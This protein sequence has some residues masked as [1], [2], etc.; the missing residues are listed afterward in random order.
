[1]P[2]NKNMKDA[3]FFWG[4]AEKWIVALALIFSV[5]VVLFYLWRFW[6]LGLGD[7]AI[8]AGFGDFVGGLVS[9]IL[10]FFTILLLIRS[11]KVQQKELA[12]ANSELSG[13]RLVHSQNLEMRHR[14]A[15]LPEFWQGLE[16]KHRDFHMA[17]T[18]DRPL[19]SNIS[20]LFSGPVQDKI[21]FSILEK[22]F[23][24]AIGKVGVD[25]RALRE[26]LRSALL[27]PR[28]EMH[29]DAIWREYSQLGQRAIA[30]IAYSSDSFTTDKVTEMFYR[31]YRTVSGFPVLTE[32][33]CWHV[34]S[35]VERALEKRKSDSIIPFYQASSFDRPE[36]SSCSLSD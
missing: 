34:R 26:Q 14:E 31:A 20:L 7:Q 12:I 1:M 19:T 21:S 27:D 29:L 30:V 23:Y 10:G 4:K 18:T 33:E 2:D 13:T 35:A 25:A 15:M 11:L 36:Q 16:L 24:R 9:P 28:N 8:F 3:S 17:W 32:Q 6:G 22:H 5:A